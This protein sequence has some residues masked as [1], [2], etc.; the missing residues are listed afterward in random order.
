MPTTAE[1]FSAGAPVPGASGGVEDVLS[2]PAS[3]L[4]PAERYARLKYF[5]PGAAEAWAATV[6][7]E[8]WSGLQYDW[9]FWGRPDQHWPQAGQPDYIDGWN[10][11]LIL[12]GRGEGK[13]RTGSELIRDAVLHRGYRAPALVAPTAA[14]ARDVMIEGNAGILACHAPHERPK[15]E[16]SKRRL[17][18][19][20]GARGAIYS[21]DDPERFRG[22]SHDLLWGDEFAIWRY[23]ELALKTI[24]FAMRHARHP[25]TILTTTP[26]PLQ[27]LRDLIKRRRT[28][29]RRG[30]TFRNL[31]N[32]PPEYLRDLVEEF[33]GTRFGAQELYA[34]LLDEAEGALWTQ[35]LIEAGRIEPLV[36]K[37]GIHLPTPQLTRIVVGVDPPGASHEHAAE[38][39]IIVAGVDEDQH[40]YVLDD[41]SLRGRPGEWGSAVV[42][43]W[44]DW[45]ADKVA[46]EDNYGGE[47]VTHVVETID[48]RCPAARVNAKG[49]KEQRAMECAAHYDYDARAGRPEGK[50]HHV[51]HFPA[52]ETEQTTWVPHEKGQKSPNRV[53]ALGHAI[54]DLLIF[55]RRRRAVVTNVGAL[56]SGRIG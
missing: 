26:K 49:S 11:L 25:R 53:D 12:K 28:I 40:A 37:G 29:V 48:S 22:P 13:T 42:Q 36:E 52:L 18:W 45:G 31:A 15:Y 30:S 23:P 21:A 3:E 33:A 51:G 41:R 17:T 38:C 8:V 19:P 46:I 47:M 24:R 27:I 14:D 56:T 16:P 10:T 50:V 5:D 2:L 9:G 54:R 34:M 39:G 32:L 4:S 55:R 20:N 7:E 1:G 44:R 43:A 35:A 6:V